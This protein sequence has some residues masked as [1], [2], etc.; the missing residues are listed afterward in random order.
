MK[1]KVYTSRLVES[2]SRNTG[3]DFSSNEKRV[4]EREIRDKEEY[5]DLPYTVD[6]PCCGSR[7]TECAN[8]DVDCDDMDHSSDGIEC[9]S[10]IVHYWECQDCGAEFA[11]KKTIRVTYSDPIINKEPVKPGDLEDEQE[12]T[13]A[14]QDLPCEIPSK[15]NDGLD[16][17][18]HWASSDV[19]G[20]YDLF[21]HEDGW[22]LGVTDNRNIGD[23]NY[24]IYSKVHP[25]KEFSKAYNQGNLGG[26]FLKVYTDELKPQI[27]DYLYRNCKQ[28]ASGKWINK[29]IVVDEDDD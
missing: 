25:F 16:A 2:S 7:N 24:G 4:R 21:R 18:I 26:L 9:D 11:V 10:R 22:A 8:V 28:D 15:Y 6:C 1:V 23:F 17:F 20:H 12:I 14:T 13:D 5:D 19:D 27:E 29:N 3:L